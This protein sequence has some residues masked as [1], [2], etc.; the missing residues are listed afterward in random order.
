MV[1]LHND[2]T[3]VA[4]KFWHLDKFSTS[5][6]AYSRKLVHL[7][8]LICDTV[9]NMHKRSKAFDSVTLAQSVPY[10]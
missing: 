4:D 10:W 3:Y 5:A 8:F 6:Q 7:F 1:I 2:D 9:F